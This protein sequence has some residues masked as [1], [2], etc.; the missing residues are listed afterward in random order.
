MRD[1]AFSQPLAGVVPCNPTMSQG[2]DATYNSE[3][4]HSYD[5]FDREACD[6]KLEGYL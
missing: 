2:G 6:L 4:T 1:P 3:E 5:V